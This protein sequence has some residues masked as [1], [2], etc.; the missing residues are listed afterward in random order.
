M[1]KAVQKVLIVGGGFSGMSAAIE[2]RKR[3]IDVDLVEID[4]GWRSYGAGITIGGATLRA[5][6]TLGILDAFL[7]RGNAADGAHIRLPHGVQVA[8]IPTPRVAGPDVP[9]SGAIMR[10][11]LAEILADA[12]RA[13]GADVRLGVTFRSINQDEDGVSVETSDGETRRYDL[14]IG[15]D[16][17]YSAM[18]EAV[19][20]DAPKPTYT[21]QAV[22]RAV[23]DTPEGIDT[24][25]MWLG[26]N[27]KVG[28]NPTSKTQSYIFI[29]EDV[30]ARQRFDDGELVSKMQ[31]LMEPFS[32]PIVQAMRAQIGNHSSIVYR[33]LESMLV[34][35]P[36]HKGRVVLIGDAV[37]ATTPHLASGA[38][39]GIE[40]AIVLAE[41]IEKAE[42]LDDAL[43]A[44]QER[45]FERCRMVVENSLRLGQIEI[46]D[47]DKE[48]H[49]KIMKDSMIALAQP[50]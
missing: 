39:I 32:D 42:S 21:G 3:N 13:S 12:T 49:G 5:F 10:P 37:H 43:P 19:M 30:P 35:G 33:P 9:G 11:V 41:E 15:A 16:G 36:W 20:P 48:E 1:N 17:L 23:V 26:P 6:R 34:R 47:G 4:P 18:R 40:D 44:F 8:T 22:W 38:C 2:L 45:R 27:V 29:T 7:E 50:V 28:V 46:N 25:I 24:A 31:A 14:V